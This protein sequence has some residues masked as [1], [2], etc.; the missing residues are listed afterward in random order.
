M[1]FL[2]VRHDLLGPQRDLRET[3]PGWPVSS[4]STLGTRLLRIDWVGAI[5]FGA[6]AILVLIGLSWGSTEYWNQGKVIGTIVS[7]GCL[8]IIFFFWEYFVG[9]YEIIFNS[10]GTPRR[11]PNVPLK[12]P[13]RIIKYT[14][15]MLPLYV[16]KNRQIDANFFA[17]FSGGMVMFG[18]LY[19]LAIYWR[20]VAGYES[21]KSGTQLVYFAP[22]L[23]GGVWI[24]T[25]LVKTTRQVCFFSIVTGPSMVS[26][27]G[28]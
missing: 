14:Q 10:D 26:L 21:T 5:V 3:I 2:L 6:G 23:G 4:H 17:A 15:R 22:G 7:G 25:V 8:I 1:S 11:D 9:K 27:P 24:W 12:H 19:F 18:C 13:P 16:F 28:Y 20:L